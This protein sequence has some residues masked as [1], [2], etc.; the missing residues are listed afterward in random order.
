MELF[1]CLEL[2]LIKYLKTCALPK[3]IIHPCAN[4]AGDSIKTLLSQTCAPEF[5]CRVAMPFSTVIRQC[6]GSIP[7]PYSTMSCLTSDVS[8][9]IVVS[10][11]YNRSA[12][13]QRFVDLVGSTFSWY[14]V[15]PVLSGSSS[16]ATRCGFSESNTTPGPALRSP[17]AFCSLK[18]VCA[19]LHLLVHSSVNS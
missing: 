4:R 3:K 1:K 18:M 11:S 6:W 15:T 12:L 8:V 16:I 14:K 19:S 10:P 5:G 9:P 17:S 2:C 7:G 13:Q